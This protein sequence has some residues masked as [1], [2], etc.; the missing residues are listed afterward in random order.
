MSEKKTRRLVAIMF[1]DIVGY[2]KLMQKSESRA[3]KI[4]DRHRKV[5][6]HF[7]EKAGAEENGDEPSGDDEKP[8]ERFGFG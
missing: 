8:E 7:H 3:V 1:T 2:T 6:E 5:F 4:R